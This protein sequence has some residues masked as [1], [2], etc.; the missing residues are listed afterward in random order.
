MATGCCEGQKDKWVKKIIRQ[1]IRK[2]NPLRAI[3]HKDVHAGSGSGISMPQIV[4]K[5]EHI[6]RKCSIVSLLWN[7][8][9][10]HFYWL[11]SKEDSDYIT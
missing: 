3:K 7:S 6:L 8:F 5:W 11:L 4:W 1:I 2:K 9:P 10:K